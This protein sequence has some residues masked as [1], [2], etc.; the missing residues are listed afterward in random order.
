M[1]LGATYLS[2]PSVELKPYGSAESKRVDE[3][4]VPASDYM[5]GRPGPPSGLITQY[6]VERT[7][8]R[9]FNGNG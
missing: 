2:G 1:G 3:S 4:Q 5:S 9:L 6:Q 8:W 7:W